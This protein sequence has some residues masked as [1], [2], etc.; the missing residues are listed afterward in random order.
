MK[1][2]T[3][4][5]SCI[6]AL[7]LLPASYASQLNEFSVF[8]PVNGVSANIY[9]EQDT[10]VVHATGSRST[11]LNTI[12]PEY[13]KRYSSRLYKIH[14][15]DKNGTVDIAVLNNVDTS[16]TRFCYKVYSYQPQSH[17]FSRQARYTQCHSP[18]GTVTYAT[19]NIDI[20][21]NH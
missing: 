21:V 11:P 10:I 5:F 3:C 17:Q 14:D 6:T 2:L 7:A 16:A 9:V 18:A 19:G 8:Q 20:A 12:R 1:A 15:V 13:L 4:V